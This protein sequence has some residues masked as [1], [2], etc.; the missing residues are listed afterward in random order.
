MSKIKIA[1]LLFKT[2]IE[3]DNLMI[4]EDDIDT[5]QT[6]VKEFKRALNGDNI[7]PSD[8]KFY[9]SAKVNQ[10][11]SSMAINM[12]NMPSKSDFESLKQQVANIVGSTGSG[13][14]SELVAARGSYSTL[15]ERLDGDMKSLKNKYVAFPTIEN[16]GMIVDCT[17][18]D[19]ADLTIKAGSY[20][21][22]TTVTVVGAN[23][24]SLDA[25]TGTSAIEKLPNLNGLKIKFT[26][27]Q[28]T[29]NINLGRTLPAGTYYLYC[30]FDSSNNFVSEGSSLKVANSDGS[31]TTITSDFKYTEVTKIVATKSITAFKIIP[32]YNTIVDGMTLTMKNIMFSEDGNLERYYPYSYLKETIKA[33][34]VYNKTFTGYRCIVSR[35]ASTLTVTAVD[36]SYDGNKIK[37]ELEA[38][39][40]V[41]VNP[42]DYCGL[43]E[44]KGTYI[45]LNKHTV[46]N[47]PD[48][49][50]TIGSDSTKTRNGQPSVKINI[51]TYN[52]DDQPRFTLQLPEV[53]NLED[54]DTLSVQMYIDKDVSERFSE[55]DGLKIMLSSDNAVANPAI[56][57]FFFNIGKNSFVQGWNTI[58][59]KLKDFYKH[60]TPNWADIKQVNFRVYTSE[61]TNG[62]CL[63]INSIIIDQRM[64]PTVLFAFDGFYDDVFNYQYPFLYGKNIP[65]TIFANDKQ[66]LTKDFID[67]VCM[68]H[69]TKGWELANYGCNPNKEI[70]IEDD[71]PREQY[72]AVKDTVQ[73]IYN[74]FTEDVISYAA[75]FGN[76]RAIS[77]P[78]LRELGFKIAKA[79]ADA[80]CSFFSDKDFVIPMHLLSNAE[81]HG[82]TAIK[83]KIDEIIETGQTLCIYTSDVT[84]YG[85]E[86]S[87]TKTSF[88]DVVNYLDRYVRLGLIQCLTFSDFYKQCTTK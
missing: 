24:F 58:K 25:I 56:N 27:A 77:E 2:E 39:K 44:D 42:E 6:T 83:A 80:Y 19:K 4:V 30:N 20:D 46:N 48:T 55:D 15:A 37:E 79:D 43:I 64:K 52:E 14:D 40:A 59:V 69:Y 63:W 87:A 16:T 18:L 85:D 86:I 32:N 57:Y 71:N 82:A 53:Q 8:Y 35:S 67:K 22:D 75:P 28:N 74:N 81:G 7:S 51:G 50:C 68:L 65:A 70:M 38:I 33:N 13:K 72:T 49:I 17:E 45:Y 5:K 62:K 54:C 29:F 60:G 11:I 21:K 76:L 23:A 73:W 66:T 34:T 78:I 9:S 36:T 31:V 88:E 3:D 41:T 26:K 10:L 84:K 1:E 47:A 12:D 61:F